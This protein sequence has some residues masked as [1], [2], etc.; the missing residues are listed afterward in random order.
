MEDPKLAL[1]AIDEAGSL[2]DTHFGPESL[3]AALVRVR[4]ASTLTTAGDYA[5]SERN[6]LEAI[7][8]LEA[9]LGKEH[10]STLAALNNLGFLH[11]RRGDQAKAEQIHAELLER[12]IAKHGRL[13]RNVAD[14]YQNLAGAI[15][16]LGRYDESIPLHREAY[17]VYRE[18]LN[19][20]NFLIAFPLLSISYAELKRGNSG[21]SEEAAREALQRFQA[22]VP[23]SFLEGVAHCLTG[24]ALEQQGSAAEGAAMVTASHPL[25]RT[26]VAPEPYRTLCRLP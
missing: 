10:S 19:E 15:T 7:P 26:G 22:T 5:G 6:F 4:L 2:A 3:Q 18:V 23:G 9:R 14:S 16:H 1:A 12:Q 25:L 21:A 8:V 13:H 24:L 17:R 20:D 11:S